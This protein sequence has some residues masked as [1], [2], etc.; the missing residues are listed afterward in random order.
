M[1]FGTKRNLLV[2]T[3]SAALVFP[4]MGMSLIVADILYATHS[5]FSAVYSCNLAVKL[6]GAEISRSPI[7]HW[8]CKTF[9]VTLP[10][11]Y[12]SEN[13]S[14]FFHIDVRELLYKK[15]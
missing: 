6:R 11:R 10:L 1:N 5:T 4:V 14:T 15:G 8:I 13:R 7:L 2:V 12:F 3:C 9:L